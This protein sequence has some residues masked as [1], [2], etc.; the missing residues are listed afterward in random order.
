MA[1]IAF[2]G[3]Y[4]GTIVAMPAS[5]LLARAFGW[6]SLFYV[7]GNNRFD[8][9]SHSNESIIVYQQVQSAVCGMFCGC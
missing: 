7:F 8:R 9:L 3:N 6:E 1:T 4:A 2:A 5:G